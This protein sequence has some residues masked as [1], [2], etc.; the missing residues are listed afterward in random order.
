MPI[1]GGRLLFIFCYQKTTKMETEK[2]QTFFFD[3]NLQN[4]LPH[5]EKRRGFGTFGLLDCWIAGLLGFRRDRQQLQK[6]RWP[7]VFVAAHISILMN[8]LYDYLDYETVPQTEKAP[9]K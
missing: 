1:G 8:P 4:Y 2:Q 5:I 3:R 6:R 9:H 7:F